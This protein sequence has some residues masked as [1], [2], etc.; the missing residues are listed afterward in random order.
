MAKLTKQMN[1][2]VN[3]ENDHRNQNQHDRNQSTEQRQIWNQNHQQNFERGNHER[4]K[5]E[6]SFHQNPFNFFYWICLPIIV[7]SLTDFLR[8][9]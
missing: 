8:L 6:K 2:T 5:V 4:K 3:L 1:A 7:R 9:N